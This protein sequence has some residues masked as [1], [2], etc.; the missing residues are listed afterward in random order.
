[1]LKIS[2]PAFEMYD[3]IQSKFIDY[4]SVTL[5]LEHSLVSIS[6]WES[7]YEKPFL[8]KEPKT[9][10][11]TMNYIKMMCLD[12]VSDSEISRLNQKHIDLIG[13]HIAAEKTATWF[14]RDGKPSSGGSGTTITSELIYYWM[15]SFN[16]PFECQHWHLNRLLTLIQVCNVRNQPAKKMSRKD[17][18]ARNRELNAARKAKYNTRG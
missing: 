2:L 18:L 17:V 3:E 1:M 10:E 12:E 4:D 11:E 14:S 9:H 7:F 6:K 16:I 15:I 8:S 5:R 13:E